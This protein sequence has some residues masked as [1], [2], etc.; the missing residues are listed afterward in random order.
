[1]TGHPMLGITNPNWC[2]WSDTPRDAQKRSFGELTV[3]AAEAIIADPQQSADDYRWYRTGWQDIQ[4]LKDGITID[5]SPAADREPRRIVGSWTSPAGC[6]PGQPSAA[7]TPD[8]P[9][10]A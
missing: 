9:R 6:P 3:R 4:Q 2:I 1:M 10:Q 5:P 7:R 8:A